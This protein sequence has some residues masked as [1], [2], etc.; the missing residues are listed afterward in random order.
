MTSAKIKYFRK[1]KA[2]Q[3]EH[4]L[5]EKDVIRYI[6]NPLNAFLIIKRA[7]ADIETV[8]KRF[9][10]DSK[11]FSEAIKE[12]Q[13]DEA[14][15][16]GAVE[17]LLRLQTVYRLKSEDFANG[18][19]DGVKTRST[20][21]PHDVFIIGREAFNLSGEDYFAKEYFNLALKM[22]KEG[23]DVD[24][25]VDESDLLDCLTTSY[26]RT[27]DYENALKTIEILIS[28]YSESKELIV[29]RD[30]LIESNKKHGK[31]NFKQQ[32]PFSDH[33]I[34]NGKYGKIKEAILF[35]RVCRG[36]LTKTLLEQ[37]QL[38]CRYLS[39]SPFSKLARF[40]VEEANLDP[41]LIVFYDVL[42]DSDIL[43]LQNRTRPIIKRAMTLGNKLE[44][45][46]S[47]QRT[48]Q[49]SFHKD[50]DHG[51]FVKISQRVEVCLIFKDND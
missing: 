44:I 51:I 11:E 12:F 30:S 5:V 17:G 35:S 22:V 39:N 31:K 50:R 32:D 46:T 37:S 33:F 28:K 13:P 15:L 21:T 19:I 14:D 24:N 38:H 49:T 1:L 16:V 41:Y 48:A 42:S 7:T 2:W 4:K 25:E 10:E 27:G 23:K 29:T 45:E 34:K 18:I 40:R 6:T 26:N 20:L 8:K 47:K 36:N 3:E 9:G 43:I